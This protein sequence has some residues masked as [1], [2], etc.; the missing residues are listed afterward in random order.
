MLALSKYLQ[1]E[2][3]PDTSG[4]LYCA[5]SHTC[6]LNLFLSHGSLVP[7]TQVSCLTNSFLPVVKRKTMLCSRAKLA[8]SFPVLQERV[9]WLN[10]LAL[11]LSVFLNNHMTLGKSPYS[12]A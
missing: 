4:L 2:Q 10:G 1:K 8:V 12:A 6:L 11:F 9:H 5:L 7:K 3:N